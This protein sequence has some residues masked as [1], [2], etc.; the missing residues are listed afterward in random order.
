MT[1]NEMK[2]KSIA[3]ID[4]ELEHG[5]FDCSRCQLTSLVGA[6]PSI[7]GG[8]YCDNNY[9]TS[10]VG[11]PASVNSFSC[12]V[13]QLTSLQDVHKH[14]KQVNGTFFVTTNPI[15]S[16]VLGLLLIKGLTAVYLDN[17]KVQG[18]LNKHLPSQGVS[19]V[20][21]AQEELIQAGFDDFAQL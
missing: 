8:F 21:E 15:K 13:N 12:S 16:H 14:I 6:P 2:Q 5:V 1:L 7:S 19:S 20:L 17:K 18:I 9:L 11:A 10:L 4:I 3:D